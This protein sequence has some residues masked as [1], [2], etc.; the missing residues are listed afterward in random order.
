MSFPH[1]YDDPNIAELTVDT[2]DVHPDYGMPVLSGVA[3]TVR[4]LATGCGGAGPAHGEGHS[5]P[6][7]PVADPAHQARD[8]IRDG[9]PATM[10]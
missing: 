10:L 5:P 8:A 2:D 1:G 6:P 3:V 9:K 4:P 7:E